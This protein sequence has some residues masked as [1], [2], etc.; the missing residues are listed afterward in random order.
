MKKV[1]LVMALVMLSGCG[2]LRINPKSCKTNALWGT[3]P[4][5][6]REITR[7]EIEEEKV[8]DIKARE[9]FYV[10]YDRDL[11]LR[12]LLEEHGIKCEE[13]KKIRVE[14]TTKWFFVREI[15]LKV[16]KN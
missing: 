5:S 2:S 7:E 4:L 13:V 1:M 15:A 3:N 16:V 12:D 9:Q 10:F 11:R 14:M 6:S 8:I